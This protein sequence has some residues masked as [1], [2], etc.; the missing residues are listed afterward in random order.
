MVGTTASNLYVPA[1]IE[2]L[3]ESAGTALVGFPAGFRPVCLNSVCSLGPLTPEMIE[4]ISRCH[5]VR[6]S[7]QNYATS[8][9]EEGTRL[10]DDETVD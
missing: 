3:F 4:I 9:D 10:N 6:L 2:R 5:C 1:V 8:R 7:T